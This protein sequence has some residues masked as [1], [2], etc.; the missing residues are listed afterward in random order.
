MKTGMPLAAAMLCCSFASIVPQVA[1]A[2]PW[3]VR[4]EMREGARSVDIEKHEAAREIGAARPATAYRVR[5][6]KA[7]VK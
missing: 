6:A 2:D 3:E 5:R 7:S 4:R 1:D